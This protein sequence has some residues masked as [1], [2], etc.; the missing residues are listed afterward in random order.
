MLH[1][2]GPSGGEESSGE[3]FA[4]FGL[5]YGFFPSHGKSQY[6]DIAAS[7]EEVDKRRDMARLQINTNDQ[8]GLTPTKLGGTNHPPGERLP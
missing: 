1:D 7:Q 3:Y 8:K 5:G 2:T 6:Q 4:V